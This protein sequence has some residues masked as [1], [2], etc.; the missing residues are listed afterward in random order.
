MLLFSKLD[1]EIENIFTLDK[2]SK[3]LQ[4]A[5]GVTLDRETTNNY[6]FFIAASNF[7]T[8][9]DHILDESKAS[10]NIKV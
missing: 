5:S 6:T 1:G 7:E 4:L 2:T 10:V 9:E 8:L 3:M